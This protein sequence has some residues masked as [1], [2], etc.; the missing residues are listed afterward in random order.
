MNGLNQSISY[1]RLIDT[2]LVTL[3]ALW[4]LSVV[5]GIAIDRPYLGLLI[6]I[7]FGGLYMVC[8]RLK[9]LYYLLFFFI[10][11][12]VELE[13]PG[14]LGID[15][16][17]EPILWVLFVLA[18]VIMVHKGIKKALIN[19]IS[20][21]IFLSLLWMFFS[22]L[23][24]LNPVV[25]FKFIA[26]KLWFVLPFYILPFYLFKEKE[27]L[28]PILKS[29]VLG[30]S[31]AAL[32]F[33]MQHYQLGLAYSERTNAGLPIWRNHVNY[34]CALTLCLPI[35]H[36]L[37]STSN[38][39]NKWVYHFIGLILFAFIYFAFARIAYICI[40]ATFLYFLILKLK[41]SKLALIGGI[42][43]SIVLVSSMVKND[44][45]VLLAPDFDKTIMHLDFQNKINATA[46]GEDISTMERLNR[47]VAGGRMIQERP[48]VGFGPGTFYRSYKPFMVF[49]FETYVSDNPDKSGI[50]NYYL[51]TFV[52]QGIIGLLIFLGFISCLIFKIQKAYSQSLPHRKEI[53][54]VASFVIIVLTMNLVNDMFEV[55]KL[56]SLFFFALFLLVRFGTF[57]TESPN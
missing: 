26:A 24:S 49:S 41:A 27:S 52:E 29:F 4:L 7:I 11:L 19:Y 47:W 57:K 42:V 3:F 36:Y 9:Q 45:Y 30:T 22:A 53:T 20:G 14:G 54:L 55:L 35:L 6:P 10:P 23:M 43:C 37:K 33:F 50:H 13:L 12:S 15:F 56:G 44:K 46:K 1:V 38:S 48:L 28:R 16:P 21:F 32:Y 25:S 40:A 18:I 39:V 2:S 8:F 51:M 31:I 5:F 34:A 17:A